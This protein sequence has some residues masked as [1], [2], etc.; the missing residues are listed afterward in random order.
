M[1]Q[2]ASVVDDL[3]TIMDKDK[4]LARRKKMAELKKR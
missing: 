4:E 2:V 1:G 3:S